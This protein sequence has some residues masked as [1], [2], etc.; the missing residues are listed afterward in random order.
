VG[1][2]GPFV[3]VRPDPQ[4]PGWDE[5]VGGLPPALLASPSPLAALRF[6]ERRTYD[7]RAN[8]KIVV[9]NFLECYHCAVAH[10]GFADLIDLKEYT[11]TPHRYCSTQRGPLKSSAKARAGAACFLKEDGGQEGSYNYL[12]P[13]FMV[14]LYPGRGNASTNIILPVA[15]DRTLAVYDFYFE[16]G[17]PEAAAMVAFID[18]VQRE[19]VVLCESVQ[20]GLGSGFCEHGR[21]MLQYE[22]GIQHFERL[23]FE[24]LTRDERREGPR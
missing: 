4:A 17:M 20:R 1:L 8:W 14:N 7:L 23:V 22:S 15:P 2:L 11:V 10:K 3:F 13:N 18:Q 21:L 24:A 5:T 6:R 16:E 9:E 19:D 12:W